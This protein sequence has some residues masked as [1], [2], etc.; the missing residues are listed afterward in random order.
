MASLQKGGNN[1]NNLKKKEA[2]FKFPVELKAAEHTQ[3]EL[4]R[5]VLICT[6]IQ[7]LPAARLHKGPGGH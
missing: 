3:D 1:D 6:E 7:H 4:K 2:T 5:L